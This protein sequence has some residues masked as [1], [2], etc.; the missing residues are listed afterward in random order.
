M[1]PTEG[2]FA[3]EAGTY[4]LE[5]TGAAARSITLRDLGTPEDFLARRMAGVRSDGDDAAPSVAFVGI[6]YG[7][8]HPTVGGVSQVDTREV[9]AVHAGEAGG[10]PFCVEVRHAASVSALAAASEQ[11]ELGVCRYWA[12]YGAPGGAMRGWLEQGGTAFALRDASAGVW[13]HPRFRLHAGDDTPFAD[14]LGVVTTGGGLRADAEACL[15][16]LLE[17][18][19]AAWSSG[20]DALAP[21]VPML[22]FG[23]ED[24]SWPFYGAEG[25]LLSDLEQDF[26]PRAFAVFWGA[27]A[28]LGDAFVRAFGTSRGAWTHAWAIER[29][30]PRPARGSILVHGSLSLVV[31]GILALI[32]GGAARRRQTA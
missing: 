20:E 24:Q 9:V 25:T 1:Y 26:G 22:G 7:P 17:R 6:A 19:E 5:G 16:G 12:R 3:L 23:A 30:G 10:R 31:C 8:E 27:D 28:S 4:L 21:G 32:A 14:L 11:A 18:C 2:R 15:Q 13:T 29:L